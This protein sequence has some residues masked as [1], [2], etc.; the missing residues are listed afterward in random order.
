MDYLSLRAQDCTA[1]TSAASLLAALAFFEEAFAAVGEILAFPAQL[2]MRRYSYKSD[3]ATCLFQQVLHGTLSN[4]E[5]AEILARR[6]LD[7]HIM[8]A[9]W[10]LQQEVSL[11]NTNKDFSF[12]IMILF[13]FLRP[14]RTV[15]LY[16]S[17]PV[18]M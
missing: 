3:S 5:F 6:Q 15:K 1:R 8:K 2:R 13:S 18:E 11:I 12:I 9:I 16:L 17:V 14:G 10:R 7:E 4:D